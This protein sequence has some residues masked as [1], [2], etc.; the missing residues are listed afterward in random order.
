MSPQGLGALFRL[1]APEPG[2]FFGN[3]NE[4]EALVDVSIEIV[5]D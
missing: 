3:R 4:S 2:H 1:G 5:A